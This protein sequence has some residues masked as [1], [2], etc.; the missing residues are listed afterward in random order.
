[1]EAPSVERNK[2][3]RI[4]LIALMLTMALAA[5]DATIVSTA[6]PQIVGD[7]GGFS[8]F[9]WLFSIYLL[10]Q[11]VT[12]P[13]YGKLADIYGRKPIMII[14]IVVFIV[15]SGICATAWN[16]V[17]LIAFRGIQAIGAG[18][19][20]ATVNTIAGDI[21]TVE[22]R[23]KVQGWLS[24]VW[25]ISAILG[26]TLGGLIVNHASWRWIF[27]INVPVGLFTIFLTYTYLHEERPSVKHKVDFVGAMFFLL[28]GT[29]AMCVLMLGGQAWNWV[30]WESLLFLILTLI[31]VMIT[32]RIEHKAHEP[33]MPKWVW[34]NKTILGANLV[35]IGAGIITMASNVYIPVFSQSVLGVGALFAGFI[36]ASQ[37]LTWPLFSSLSGKLY[38]RIG[39]RNT[40]FYGIVL[41]LL[42]ASIFTLMYF[43]G[44][45]WI[46]ISM[47][48]VLGAGFGLLFT[49]LLVGIQS[50]VEWGRRG[51]VTGSNMFSRYIGQS[52]GTAIFAAVFNS[53]L[54]ESL[55]NA[56]KKTSG[57][58][59]HVNEVISTLQKHDINPEVLIYL[60]RSF[61]HATQQVYLGVIFIGII[62]FFLL[63]IVPKKFKSLDK[64]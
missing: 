44:K 2:H 46:L 63:F 51:T 20:V 14:G 8:L 38:L 1:M 40:S 30:S 62:T 4:I 12:I 35:T 22:E 36:L 29:L 47:Q 13:I 11:T 7:L 58:L 64:N 37:S 42:G 3:K 18:A 10:I 48:L 27:L 15:G 28:S 6:I 52:L 34:K 50:I 24:S 53:S 54:I 41:A 61:F 5:M 43:P 55:K 31:S 59:P 21:Y 33:I 25:G 16:M 60:K 19:I 39:F 45:P 49:P 32:V 26:P 17:S 9:S 23:A 57:E 56:P